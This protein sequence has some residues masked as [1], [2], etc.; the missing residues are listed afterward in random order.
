MITGEEPLE[1]TAEPAAPS[2]ESLESTGYEP[3]AL[4]GEEIEEIIEVGGVERELVASFWSGTYTKELEASDVEGESDDE[5]DP[6]EIEA[7]EGEEDSAAVPSAQFVVISMPGMEI[8]GS[9]RNPFTEMKTEELLEEMFE[10][11]ADGDLEGLEQ[12]ESRT[13]SVLE[14][15]R[16]VDVFE[17]KS[18]TEDG[19]EASLTLYV[20][21]FSNEEDIIVLFGGRPTDVEGEDDS[22]ATLFESVDH[23]LEV[24]AF[25]AE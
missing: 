12:Q 22:I 16:T 14:A 24:S 15:D 21:R 13:Y 10:D 6:E 2:D 7:A 17:A 23:P 18:E 4:E 20:T 5:I 3:A 9:N 25:G 8:A 1:F 11:E 19:E